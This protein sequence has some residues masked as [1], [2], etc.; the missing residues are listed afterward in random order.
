[1]QK[2]TLSVCMCLGLFGCGQSNQAPSSPT[3]GTTTQA[4][5]DKDNN[6]TSLPADAPVVQVVTSGVL[7][8]L[9][10]LDDKGSLQGIDV[11]I[12][13]AIGEDQG[14][15][16]QIVKDDFAN[17]LAGIT[18]GKYQVAISGLSLSPERTSKYGHTNF[19]M[20]NPPVVMYD[21]KL[22]VTDI[23]SLK[24][25]R[26][27]TMR[28]TIQ[29]RLITEL[30][31]A[32]HERTETV[33]QLFQGLVQDEYDAVLQ[34]KYFLEYIAQNYP[35]HKFSILEYD[36]NEQAAGI[37]MYTKKDDQ[38]LIDKLNTGIDNLKAKGEIDKIISKYVNT[39]DSSPQETEK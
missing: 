23:N 17:M 15:R 5:S 26:V 8:P 9:T 21:P 7:P 33:F 19:Y 28:D 11:D 25:L 18:E 12:I 27:A 32:S 39:A 13:H 3:T 37:V 24:P 14:I 1:M 35:E 29:D 34:D 16:I 36:K 22:T 30:H 38:E 4:T 20:S 10:F 6:T 2:F 31:P